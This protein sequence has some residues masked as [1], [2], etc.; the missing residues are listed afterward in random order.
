LQATFDE[1]SLV[2]DAGLVLMAT[3]V[4][5]LGLET[6]I[7]STVRLLGRVG[8]CQRGRG[9]VF[10]AVAVALED[11]DF[12]VVH[13]AVDHGFDGGGVAEDFGPGGEALVG[14]DDEA[15]SFVAAGDEGEE[16]GG[17]VGIEGDVA[18]LVDL[19]RARHRSTYADAVTM[20][21]DR[22]GV[23]AGLVVHDRA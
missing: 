22:A 8:G 9:S 7:N 17:G 16:Q 15:G 19:C 6:L 14:A 3:S 4:G 23:V 5:R 10:E 2:A 13:E 18:D 1:E 21:T 20:P 11:D 12:G